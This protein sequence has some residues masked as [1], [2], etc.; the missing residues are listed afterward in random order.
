MD[1]WIA[2]LHTQEAG[3]EAIAKSALLLSLSTG[4][5]VGV[6][7]ILRF[8]SSEGDFQSVSLDPHR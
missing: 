5:Y 7:L 1:F 2:C 4:L 6:H 8:I 3:L